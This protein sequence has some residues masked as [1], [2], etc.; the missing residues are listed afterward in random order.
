MIAVG[1]EKVVSI[2]MARP[3]REEAKN[4]IHIFFYGLETLRNPIICVKG[5][6]ETM[7]DLREVMEEMLGVKIDICHRGK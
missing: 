6:P 4:D 5:K 2:S 1:R 7:T 3:E